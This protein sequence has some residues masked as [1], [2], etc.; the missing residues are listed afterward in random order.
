MFFILLIITQDCKRG[1]PPYRLGWE[2]KRA[3]FPHNT[4]KRGT[5][6]AL[7]LGW[8][9]PIGQKL[10]WRLYFAGKFLEI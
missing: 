4:H 9:F 7:R 8:K 1:T 5:F 6:A 2:Y 3:R 10:S